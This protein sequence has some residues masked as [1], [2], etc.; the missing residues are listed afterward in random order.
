MNG[1]EE[2]GEAIYQNPESSVDQYIDTSSSIAPEQDTYTESRFVDIYQNQISQQTQAPEN[3]TNLTDLFGKFIDV[4][5]KTASQIYQMKYGAAAGKNYI[6]G[7]PSKQVSYPSSRTPQ[8]GLN[9]GVS[10]T[11]AGNILAGV[12]TQS[13]AVMAI[14][15]IG[16][17]LAMRK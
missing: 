6:I 8:S 10:T 11:G 2:L 17:I 12:S 5:G 1:G 4:A 16:A 3:T 9:T 15:V 14:I 7:D 13:W